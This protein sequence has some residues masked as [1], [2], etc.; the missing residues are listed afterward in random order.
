[1]KEIISLQAKEDMEWVQVRIFEGE[2]V[3]NGKEECDVIIFESGT[4]YS[5]NHISIVA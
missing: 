1:M 2:E 5:N 3:K 4:W